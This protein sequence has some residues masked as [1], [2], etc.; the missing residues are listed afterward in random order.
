MLGLVSSWYRNAWWSWSR[1]WMPNMLE[2]SNVWCTHHFSWARPRNPLQR[3]ELF[4]WP[5]SG[6]FL[7]YSSFLAHFHSSMALE[8]HE[9]LADIVR[10]H[11]CYPH[12]KWFWPRLNSKTSMENFHSLCYMPSHGPRWCFVK[13]ASA[14]GNSW[15]HGHSGHAQTSVH[16]NRP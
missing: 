6:H 3:L 2:P 1:Y 14:W 10:Y 13:E 12:S 8:P 16:N 4:A 7:A 11:Y 5:S 15:T 9:P